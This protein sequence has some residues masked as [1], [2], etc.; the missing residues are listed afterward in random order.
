MRS[1]LALWIEGVMAVHPSL[2]SSEKS[3]GARTVGGHSAQAAL[4]SAPLFHVTGILSRRC[5]SSVMG[6]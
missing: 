4:G 1:P 3:V 6:S 5:A 2:L